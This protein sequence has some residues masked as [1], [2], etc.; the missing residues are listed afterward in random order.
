MDDVA[1][2][3]GTTTTAC[4]WGWRAVVMQQLLIGPFELKFDRLNT[5]SIV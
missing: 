4:R 1:A 3:A 2:E 5:N